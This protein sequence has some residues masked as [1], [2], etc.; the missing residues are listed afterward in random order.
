MTISLVEKTQ[1]NTNLLGKER[2][3]RDTSDEQ[4]D[5]RL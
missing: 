4:R 1:L 2:G 5:T 3:M